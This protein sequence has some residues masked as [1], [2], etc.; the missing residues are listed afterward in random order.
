MEKYHAKKTD[1]SFHKNLIINCILKTFT[2]K[3]FCDRITFWS[4]N[5]YQLTEKQ[6]KGK[7]VKG[8][9]KYSFLCMTLEQN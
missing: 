7:E 3:E 5:N 2:D 9:V 1:K 4:I 6:G 8:S